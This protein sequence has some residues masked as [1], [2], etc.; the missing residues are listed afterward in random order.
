M[1]DSD[2]GSRV[3][4]G[5]ADG[6]ERPFLVADIVDPARAVGRKKLNRV[7]G[8]A[9]VM[10]AAML[11]AAGSRSATWFALGALLGCSNPPGPLY[12]ERAADR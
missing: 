6:S 11:A 8:V 10:L 2:I 4:R 12:A 5:G 3:E 7:N 9:A 1:F